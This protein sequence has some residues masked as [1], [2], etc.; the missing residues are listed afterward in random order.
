MTNEFASSIQT[1][2]IVAISSFDNFYKIDEKM[3]LNQQ[4]VVRN[5]RISIGP[6]AY[7]RTIFFYWIKFHTNPTK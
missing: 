1:L 4:K 7:C 5:I 3:R 2:S 6:K